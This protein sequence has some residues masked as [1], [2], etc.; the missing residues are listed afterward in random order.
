M[1]SIG[2]HIWAFA[3]SIASKLYDSTGS[4]GS[5]KDSVNVDLS[6]STTGYAKTLTTD[7]NKVYWTDSTFTHNQTSTSAT[8]TITH[9]LNKYPSVMVIDSADTVV[10]GTIVYNSSNQLTIT[11]F[12]E[13]DALAFQ[14]KAYLN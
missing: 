8:W 2:K 11:F 6:S 4:S 9:N 5:P 13:S 3:V 12:E 1:K 7:G 14:G 10:Q